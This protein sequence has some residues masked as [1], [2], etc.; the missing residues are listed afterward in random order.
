M[1]DL[2]HPNCVKLVSYYYTKGDNVNFN[3]IFF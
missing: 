3:I 2:S 1:Q